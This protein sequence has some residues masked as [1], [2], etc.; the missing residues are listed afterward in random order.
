[1]PQEG[2]CVEI[3]IWASQHPLVLRQW[4]GDDGSCK[5]IAFY[6]KNIHIQILFPLKESTEQVEAWES[7]YGPT[8]VYHFILKVGIFSLQPWGCCIYLNIVGTP[9]LHVG[10]E[11]YQPH[12]H[13]QLQLPEAKT[14]QKCSFASY[15]TWPH[16]HGGRSAQTT[17]ENYGERTREPVIHITQ[18]D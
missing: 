3:D 14:I 2:L 10:S 4:E 18:F 16:M 6:Y 9:S 7:Q 15:R 13:S 17:E 8:F 5:E 1:M 12:P 11:S